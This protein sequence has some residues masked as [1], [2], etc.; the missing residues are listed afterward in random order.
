MENRL[1]ITT[2]C[3]AAFAYACGPW[4]H[5]QSI[6]QA[7]PAL[8]EHAHT[9][10]HHGSRDSVVTTF[11]VTPDG[12]HVRFALSI[13]NST[14]KTVELRF[15]TGRTHD[16][17]VLDTRGDT[18]WRWSEGR[19]FTQTMQTRTVTSNDENTL[20][21]AWNATGAHGHFTAVALLATE[22]H[23]AERRVDFTLP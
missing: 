4:I 20:D 8:A 2:L 7:A 10:A 23:P 11:K 14:P 3:V 19:L 13:V 9:P 18:V 21:E 16:F 15:P 1:V 17:A 6:A 12:D 22:T 5:S